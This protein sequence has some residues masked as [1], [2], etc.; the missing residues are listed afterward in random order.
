MNPF[1]RRL[2][3]VSLMV[4]SLG[5]AGIAW[6]GF[7]LDHVNLQEDIVSVSE[8]PAAESDVAPQIEA[9]AAMT[10]E[11]Y[12]VVTEKPIF[13]VDREPYVEKQAVVM[14]EN[15]ILNGQSAPVDN[16]D[17]RLNAVVLSGESRIALIQDLREKMLFTVHQGESIKGWKVVRLQARSVTLA[18]GGEEML[19]E[20]E[21]KPN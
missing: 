12:A 16:V 2:L 7:N 14:D 15:A 21:V 6:Y 10:L 11:Q 17:L 3:S 1:L 13:S 4:C 18:K 8:L 20:L 19:L 5:F 9:Q